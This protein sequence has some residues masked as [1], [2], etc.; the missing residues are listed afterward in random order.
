[1]GAVYA[2][3]YD[4]TEAEIDVVARCLEAVKLARAIRQPAPPTPLRQRR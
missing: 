3:L 4:M 1:M 2:G